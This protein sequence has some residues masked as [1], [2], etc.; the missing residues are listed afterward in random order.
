MSEHYDFERVGAYLRQV[1]DDRGFASERAFARRYN[2]PRMTLR[3]LLA[4]ERV[5]VD[6]LILVAEALDVPVEVFFQLCGYLPVERSRSR[7]LD[8]VEALLRGLD[9]DAQRR[10]R[11]L[12][13]DEVQRLQ[14]E[15]EEDA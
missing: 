3:R 11:D 10:I 2:L 5:D 4:G 9:P 7:L 6:S 12:V 15:G 13:R 8:E 1:M 14:G